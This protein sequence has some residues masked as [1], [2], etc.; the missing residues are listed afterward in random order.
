MKRVLGENDFEATLKRWAGAKAQLWLYHVSH[1]RLAIQLSH[2]DDDEV[3]YILAGGCKHICGPFWWP[4]AHVVIEPP[5][6]PNG[7]YRVVD[8]AAGFELTCSGL[9]MA[10]GPA[11]EM[12]QSLENFLGDDQP[13]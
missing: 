6:P 9:G 7:L 8:S 13:P 10:I 3:L 12:D 2:R 11:N 5:S 1:S 4:G